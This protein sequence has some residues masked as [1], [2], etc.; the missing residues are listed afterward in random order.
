MEGGKPAETRLRVLERRDRLTFV[1]LEPVTGRTNQL[2]IHCS[3][4][5]HPVVGDEWYA[6][7]WFPRLCLHAA[8]LAFHHPSTNEW[9]SFE[10]PL[11]A[12]IAAAFDAGLIEGGEL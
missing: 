12:S 8:R 1:E 9:M 2:R 4:V 3:H 5:G 11:P 6:P 7:G 10:A